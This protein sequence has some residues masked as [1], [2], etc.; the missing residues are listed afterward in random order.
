[1]AFRKWQNY[2]NFCFII[3]VDVSVEDAEIQVLFH[4]LPPHANV[5]ELLGFCVNFPR[6]GDKTPAMAL[7]MPLHSGGSLTQRIVTLAKEGMFPITF[8][9]TCETTTKWNYSM[10]GRVKII[11]THHGEVCFFPLA[12]PTSTGAEA[13]PNYWGNT[14]TTISRHPVGVQI[15]EILQQVLANRRKLLKEILK[16]C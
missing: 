6:E 8:E 12:S 10:L 5:V 2:Y 9:M 14:S 16:I 1:M 3:F 11:V 13:N 15:R 4:L 7:L